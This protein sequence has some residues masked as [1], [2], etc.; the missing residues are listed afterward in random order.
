MLLDKEL[1][2]SSEIGVWLE[3]RFAE[4]YGYPLFVAAQSPR[5]TFREWLSY[6]QGVVELHSGSG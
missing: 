6:I 4:L 2:L 1:E 3:F 5:A